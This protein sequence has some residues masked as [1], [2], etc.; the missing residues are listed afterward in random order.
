MRAVRISLGP[1]AVGELRGDRDASRFHFRPDYLDA[2]DRAVLGQWFEDRLTSRIRRF[3]RHFHPWF[4]NALPERGGALR[5]RLTRASG[6]SEDDD[7]GLLMRLGENL[8][9]NV[10]AH[11][12]ANTGPQSDSSAMGDEVIDE[13]D[14]VSRGLRVSLGGIQLKFAL[15]GQPDRLTLPIVRED[16]SRWILKLPGRGFEDLVATEFGVMNWCRAAGFHVP[17]THVI[18]RDAFPDELGDLPEVSSG[19]LIERFDRSDVGRIH[20]EDFAQVLCVHPESKYKAT[21]ALGLGR[22]VLA[23]LGSQGFEEYLRRLVAVVATGNADAHLKN[24]S[25]LYPD[26]VEPEWSPM[27]DQVSTV[28]FKGLETRLAMRIGNA[29]YLRQ[30]EMS[31]L[32]WLAEQVGLSRAT[33]E[34]AVDTTIIRLRDAFRP[35]A[36]GMPSRVAE[37]LRGYWKEV[38]LLRRHGLDAG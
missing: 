8:P 27:Y 25:L 28:A 12:V 23:I 21:D 26:G 5:A 9:G 37:V 36:I 22:F 16:D 30:V 6:L 10:Y 38:P 20:Q 15:S 32:C 1:R 17:E 35:E 7:F 3:R 4:D 34:S 14:R 13:P 24:W 19:F 33:A 29:R 2:P 11:Q 31:H 18:P